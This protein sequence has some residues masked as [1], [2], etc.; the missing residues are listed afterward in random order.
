MPCSAEARSY[1]GKDLINTRGPVILDMVTQADNIKWQETDSVLEAIILESNLIKKYLPKYNT[2]EKD[3]K[4]FNYVCI[5]HSA[6]QDNLET[7]TQ[8][9]SFARVL[10]LVHQTGSQKN[11][12]ASQFFSENKLPR[13]LVVRG[14]NLNK[15]KYQEIYGPFPNGSQ[16][17]E[18]MKIIRRIFP[19]IDEHSSKKN[20]MVFYRQLELTPENILQ[21]KNNIKNLKLF[22]EGKKKKIILNLKR[23]MAAF[24]KSKDFENAAHVRD[25]I[26]ALGHINDVAL[27]KDGFIGDNAFQNRITNYAFRIEAYDIAH[28][29]G[30]NMVGVMVVVEDGDLAKSEYKKFII[31]TQKNANDTGALEEILSRRF[32]HVEWALP[33][34]IVVDGSTAQINVA[35]KVLKTGPQKNFS[36]S[37]VDF[38]ASQKASFARVLGLV[39]QTGS[40]KNF[41]VPQL[42]NIS[43]VGVVKDERHKAKA[44]IGDEAI[45]QKYKKEILLANSESHRFAIAYHKKKRNQNFLK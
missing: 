17:K 41:S 8:K 38:A 4:S 20:N 6:L 43:I 11:F 19:Y 35:K 3:N 7:T 14:R 2:K 36:A 12:S 27:I 34:M 18:A 44:I 29:S 31:K 10:G 26:F 40:Q 15:E 16:L 28:M 22:F 45:I 32:R 37:S 9:A 1:F 23:E 21:Y 33:N 25:Q 5:T 42:Q 30:K 39:H 13:V 24:S